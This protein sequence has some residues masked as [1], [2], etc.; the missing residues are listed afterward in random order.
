[1]HSRPAR[2]WW[3]LHKQA[4]CGIA[5]LSQVMMHV[6]AM[7]RTRASARLRRYTHDHP[8]FVT[9]PLYCDPLRPCC[10]IRDG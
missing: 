4:R 7:R 1:M 3:N 10:S 9:P 2:L 8:Q 5:A 6:S